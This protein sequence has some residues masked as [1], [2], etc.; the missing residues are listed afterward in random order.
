RRD[1]GTNRCTFGFAEAPQH[2]PNRQPFIRRAPG[3]EPEDL[4]EIRLFG[5][6]WTAVAT[7]ELT[8]IAACVDLPR[9]FALEDATGLHARPQGL[10][11]QLKRLRAT[12]CR[13]LRQE[14]RDGGVMRL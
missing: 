3:C 5:F 9:Q 12:G 2:A 10:N 7:P 13:K 8:P 11:G 4:T 1:S 14:A 6:V